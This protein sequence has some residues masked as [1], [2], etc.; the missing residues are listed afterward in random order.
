DLEKYD[1]QG[2]EITYTVKEEDVPKGYTSNVDDYEIT[3][4]QVSTTVEGKKIWSEVDKRYRP[5]TVTIQLLANGVKETTVEVSAETGWEYEFSDSAKYDK[6]GN[7]ITYTVEEINV[8]KGYESNVEGYTITNTQ[9]TTE[10][11]RASCRI[12]KYMY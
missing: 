11:G 4:T 9:V 7:E 3:N 8:P 1:D 5:D 2:K 6:K 10:I 12:R